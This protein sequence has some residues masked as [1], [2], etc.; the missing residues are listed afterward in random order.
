MSIR[1]V[2]ISH[3]GGEQSS[4][5][6]NQ[7]EVNENIPTGTILGRLEG[8]DGELDLANLDI[9]VTRD[10]GRFEVFYGEHNGVMGYY[11]RVTAG[12][13][14]MLNFEDEDNGYI[15]DL[16]GAAFQY[17]TFEFYVDKDNPSTRT[18][19]ASLD[20]YLKD[21][22]PETPADTTPAIGG[23]AA[24][25]IEA[26]DA[27]GNPFAGVM[28]TND[29][30]QESTVFISF[31]KAA[32]ALSGAGLTLVTDADTMVYS[33][34]AANGT[35][36]ATALA[37]LDFD[38]SNLTVG[39][40]ATD[41]T[42]TLTV[43]D[44][45][46]PRDT[47][48]GQQVGT[49]TVIATP[50]ADGAPT[51]GSLSNSDI[52]A[53]G[54]TGNP[55][56][57]VTITNDTGQETTVFISFAKAAGVLS[58]AGLTLV[59]DADTMVYSLT[60][61]NAT[62][63]AAALA[64]LDFDPSNLTV[65]A[66]ATDTTFT[67]TVTDAGHPRDTAIGPQ[68]DTVT[69]TATPPADGAPTIGGL[70]GDKVSVSANEGTVNPF[71]G[72]TINNET[73]QE[74]T[75]FIKF[76]AEMGALAGAGLELVEAANTL[77]I[78]T[79]RVMGTSA[80][81]LQN[82]LRAL[83][84]NPRDLGDGES[85]EIGFEVTVVDPTHLTPGTPQTDTVILDSRADDSAPEIG[86]L[87]TTPVAANANE[88]TV[89]PFGGVTIANEASQQTVATITFQN[90]LGA[91][92]GA[93]L[94]LVGV[95]NDT[96]IVTYTV[97]GTSPSN[98]RD[99]LRGLT[100][101]PRN[102]AAGAS[103]NITFTVKLTD[104]NHA[105]PGVE[106]TGTVTVASTAPTAP[107]AAPTGLDL[108]VKF[109]KEDAQVG[110]ELGLLNAFDPN[111]DNPLIYKLIDSAGGRFA[112]SGNKLVLAGPGVNFEEAKSHQI[113][114]EVSDGKGGTEVKTFTINVG[115]EVTLVLNGKTT[116]DKLNGGERDDI[117]NGMKGNDTVKGLSGDDKLY[118]DV[119]DDKVYGGLGLDTLYG[120][121]GNDKL[122]GDAGNDVLYG[123]EGNDLLYGGLGSDTFVFTKKA[124]KATNFDQIKDFRSGEDKIFLDSAV[125]KKLGKL[126]TIDAPA[127]LDPNMFSISKAKDK[128]DFLVYKSGV[129]YY[130]ADG[131]GKGA[132]VEIMKVKGLKATDIFI[133]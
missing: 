61:A 124:N 9:V 105:T 62:A 79:Y 103:E 20:V 81:D 28:I 35:A 86:G 94:T 34:T 50:P 55:F 58:G 60:A 15:E 76:T 13:D 77:G 119:G 120:G 88:G 123:D 39:A 118:G 6:D 72:V 75:A 83:T 59:T 22:N 7:M 1:L 98:L 70:P 71:D 36:L 128:K 27:T 131:S 4:I 93:G 96:G 129:L 8:T 45:G 52:A 111:G 126:G 89:K 74:T 87:S 23:L 85:E 47:A 104:P 46:H 117:L 95:D 67:L 31:A 66:T 40:T 109:I 16:A 110:S 125:F 41:T 2:A 51:V 122:Y 99:L 130:D 132:A 43:T 90:N 127:K 116:N 10:F 30:G 26:N 92:T 18:G 56:A 5:N 29:T 14:A 107:N 63:L 82:K 121:K 91:L 38:P 21:V 17:L 73:G 57:G 32:G 3:N 54:A 42:F 19:Q 113:K 24:S 100:F 12:G 80:A 112:I 68:V 37:A 106:Q 69:V 78:V 114:V 48:T 64:A 65:G 33:L 102:L 133:I 49:V 44:A 115:D 97:T 84:F 101:D 108:S 53:N 25:I 11:L